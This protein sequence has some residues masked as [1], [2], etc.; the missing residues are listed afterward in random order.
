MKKS[1][2]TVEMKIDKQTKY[3]NSSNNYEKILNNY[4]PS[5]F[6]G[7]NNYHVVVACTIQLL[8]LRQ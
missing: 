1:C 3:F 5:K 8:P 7:L 2:I 4:I 6:K